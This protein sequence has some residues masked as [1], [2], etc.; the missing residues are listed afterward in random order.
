M[1]LYLTESVAWQP[2]HLHKSDWRFE[3][4]QLLAAGIR[5]AIAVEHGAV[6]GVPDAIKGEVPAA[7]IVLEDGAG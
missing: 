3:R 6:I 2:L 5:K 7:Y 1:L 4:G